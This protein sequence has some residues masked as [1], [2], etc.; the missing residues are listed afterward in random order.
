MQDVPQFVLNR[1]Q[2]KPVPGSHPDADLLTAFA[3]Q[4]LAGSE[5]ALVMEHLA[6][7][8]DC[9]D[10][11]ALAL[12]VTEAVAH[13]SV[14][15]P[16]IGWLS[17]PILRWSALAAGIVVVASA[18][19]LEYSHR[20]Q[21]QAAASNRMQSEIAQLPRTLNQSL[22]T[23]NPPSATE[24]TVLQTEARKKASSATNSKRLTLHEPTAG[25]VGAAPSPAGIGAGSGGGMV[26][27]SGSTPVGGVGT[28]A[29]IGAGSGSSDRG[30]SFIQP[31]PQAKQGPS[32]QS[33]QQH[34]ATAAGQ[35]KK[36]GAASE[37]VTVEVQ[38]EA[39]VVNTESAAT[40]QN[41]VITQNQTNL[42]L[43]G[44]N[45]TDLNVVKA[46]DPVPSQ[47]AASAPS[48]PALAAP[49]QMS[50]SVM[51]RPLPQWSISPAGVLQRSFDGG[52]TWEN[53]NPA[54]NTASSGSRAGMAIAVRADPATS[55]QGKQNQ[56]AKAA[57]NPTPAFRAVAATGSDVWAG[58]VGSILYHTSD[59]GNLWTRVTL[60]AGGVVPTGDIISIRFTDPQ[61]GELS[62]STGE[63]WS[64]SD[65]GQT[66]KKQH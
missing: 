55:D 14:A 20:N 28:G 62:T 11:V 44:R 12:P 32:A 19:V 64:T 13:A 2:A 41:Q 59:A 18:G 23:L 34:S 30:A 45:F 46:K 4:S 57:R 8:A 39:G 29:G 6:A 52:N 63:L 10:V 50:Q 27:I 58:G 53:V 1:L 38:A 31:S 21:Q 9:R 26:V 24:T 42:P 40:G 65:N 22:P 43:N 25:S 66:W 37:M 36:I 61:H 47:A 16:R 3:E 56:D 17:S 48:A 5:R 35:Q 60:S 7:C 51:V 15:T 49:M 54:L 33:A